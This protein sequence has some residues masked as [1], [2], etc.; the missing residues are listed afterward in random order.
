MLILKTIRFLILIISSYGWIVFLTEKK[1]KAEFSVMLFIS[2]TGSLMFAAGLLNILEITSLFIAVAGLVFT[3]RSLRKGQ[4]PVDLLS[5]GIIFFIFSLV[6]LFAL[7]YGT[8]FT[9]YDNFSH[10]AV[11]AREILE[12]NRFPNFQ[13]QLITFQSYPPG[14]AAFIYYICKVSGIHSEWMMMYAQGIA[15]VG[16]LV[17]LFAFCKKARNIVLPIITI[18]FI[19]CCN[20]RLVDICVDTLLLCTGSAGVLFCI[21]YQKRVHDLYPALIPVLIFLVSIKNSGIFFAAGIIVYFLLVCG[22]RN[23]KQAVILSAVTLVTILLWKQHVSLVFESGMTTKHSMSL[24]NLGSTFTEKTKDDILQITDRYLKSVF[25]LRNEFF[26]F[27]VGII[28]LLL[29]CIKTKKKYRS[30]VIKNS[31]FCIMIYIVYQFSLLGMYLFSMPTNEAMNMASYDRYH[32]TILGFLVIIMLP[33]VMSVTFSK[34]QLSLAWYS[35]TALVEYASL[36]PDLN[37][38]LRIDWEETERYRYEKVI[39]DYEVPVRSSYLVLRNDDDYGYS[40]YFYRY[41][42]ESS[43]VE[44]FTDEQLPDL[45]EIR[46]YYEYII[47]LDGTEEEY[48]YV[49]NTLGIDSTDRVIKLSEWENQ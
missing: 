4:M 19:L 20:I 41:Y 11:V 31:V 10:W 40:Y 47:I 12:N 27:A 48:N 13:D 39:E 6:A 29:F 46:D 15:T 43:Q 28:C 8:K 42:L 36:T 35:V 18:I 7:L 34:M 14:S 3:I 30:F 23:L 32:M 45:E 21:Y 22:K 2:G 49:Q 44:V 33:Q 5:W 17:P 37:Y 16:M 1:I 26:Y 24:A 9:R 38:L 25:T